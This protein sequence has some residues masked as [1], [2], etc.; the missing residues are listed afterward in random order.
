[1]NLGIIVGIT[2]VTNIVRALR[3]YSDTKGKIAKST[4]YHVGVN[5]L[6]LR[7]LVY[8]M[9]NINTRWIRRNFQLQS[10]PQLK[11]KRS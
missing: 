1:M 5:S 8:K 10:Q 3:N 7:E 9:I 11:L 6:T 2:L 4:P